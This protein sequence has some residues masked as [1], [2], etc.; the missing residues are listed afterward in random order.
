[1]FNGEPL[2]LKVKGIKLRTDGEKRLCDVRLEAEI[3]DD[4]AGGLPDGHARY[5]AL[6]AGSEKRT[7]LDTS[8]AIF[9]MV[10]STAAKDDVFKSRVVQVLEVPLAR[11]DSEEGGAAGV[12]A[13][14]LVSLP[15]SDDL[16]LYLFHHY[17]D[18]D[19][20]FRLTNLQPSL[21]LCGGNEKSEAKTPEPKRQLEMEQGAAPKGKAA[22][23][24]NGKNGKRARA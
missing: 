3:T 23:K 12:V 16:A 5:K 24:S 9:E 20:T 8:A 14:P 13:R 2:Q 11:K 6:E 22:K 4:I 7:V 19:L 21:P 18:S 17:A 10:M 15:V 1:M